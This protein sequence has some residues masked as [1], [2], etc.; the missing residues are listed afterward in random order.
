MYRLVS[1]ITA[2]NLL[3]DIYVYIHTVPALEGGKRC[4]RIKCIKI[5]GY[6]RLYGNK[7]MAHP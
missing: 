1:I 7:I 3:T 2:N 6:N 4:D 5:I